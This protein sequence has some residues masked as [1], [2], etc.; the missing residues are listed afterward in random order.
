M[1]NISS[2]FDTRRVSGV[3]LATVLSLFLVALITY[4]ATTISTNISTGGT[5]TVTD[6]AT[7]SSTLAVTG[8]VTANGAITLGD[9]A[10]DVITITGNASPSNSLTVGND[11]FV[12]GT[13]STSDARIGGYDGANGLIAGVLAG[14]CNL[15]AATLAASTTTNFPCTSATGVRSG[16]KVFV[17]ATSSL[18]VGNPY[19]NDIIIRAASSSVSGQINVDIVNTDDNSNTETVAGTLNFWAVR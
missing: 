8:A 5:L 4:G 12:T 19:A 13:A 10:A 1:S 9:A 3:V 11:L 17:M 7:L 2:F 14:T 16:D 6:A 18:A 15:T